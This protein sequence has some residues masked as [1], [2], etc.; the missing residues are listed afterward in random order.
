MSDAVIVRVT[1]DD[2]V[3]D[4]AIEEADKEGRVRLQEQLPTRY[5]D[6]TVTD[7]LV[8]RWVRDLIEEALDGMRN[9][10]PVIRTGRSLVLAGNAGRGKTWQAWGALR[11]LAVSGVHCRWLFVT[12]SDLFA[13]LRPR[14]G[15]DSEDVFEDLVGAAV[16][17]IDDLG[18]AKDSA[19]TEDMLGRIVDR[20]SKWIRPTLITT[21]VPPP[22]FS[23]KFGNR[24][25]SRLT[26]M[27]SVVPFTGPDLRRGVPGVR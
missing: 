1:L 11:A 17:V 26:E 3:A 12:A 22:A 8:D 15:I 23:D 13:T 7:P 14:H 27:A 4:Y 19:W 9:Q 18:A 24:V 10:Y 16:L 25:A 6:A 2:G 5:A 20:R 21:N